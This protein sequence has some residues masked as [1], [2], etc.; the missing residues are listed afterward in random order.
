MADKKSPLRIWIQFNAS[1]P[2]QQE[3]VEFL[4]ACGYWKNRI[5]SIMVKEFVEAHNL[6]SADKEYI[7]RF[8][9]SYDFVNDAVK[10]AARTQIVMAVSQ[11][12]D[13]PLNLNVAA[14]RQNEPMNEPEN[15]NINGLNSIETADTKVDDEKAAAALSAFGL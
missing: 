10:N 11:V 14:G 7:K 1:D 6:K 15:I 5:L 4:N 13:E 12:A 8:I 9:N 3:A 2:K